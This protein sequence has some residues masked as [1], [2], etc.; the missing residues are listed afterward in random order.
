LLQQAFGYGQGLAMMYARHPEALPWGLP[1]RLRRA[2]MTLRRR[3]GAIT[4]KV[5]QRLGRV[6]PDEA[7]FAIYLD[8]WNGEYWRGFDAEWRTIRAAR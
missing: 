5:G 8:M 2:R 3:M 1:Q 4:Q 6:T 7:E